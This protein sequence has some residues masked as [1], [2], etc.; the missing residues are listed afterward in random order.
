[1]LDQASG[2]EKNYTLNKTHTVSQ[3]ACSA[4]LLAALWKAKDFWELLMV[5]CLA[6]STL[7]CVLMSFHGCLVPRLVVQFVEASSDPLTCICM[8]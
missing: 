6:S 1:M 8:V 4:Q 2:K 3:P 7:A 5:D